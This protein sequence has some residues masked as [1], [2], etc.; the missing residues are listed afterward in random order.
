LNGD[1][2]GPQGDQFVVFRQ[3]PKPIMLPSRA[4]DGANSTM[5]PGRVSAT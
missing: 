3:E 2:A 1:S 5:R 4:V